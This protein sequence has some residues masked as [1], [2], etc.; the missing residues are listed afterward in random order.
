[1]IVA[2]ISLAAFSAPAWMLCQKTWDVPF[3]ITAI[4]SPALAL[5]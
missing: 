1:M 3:G 2:P 4:V 5:R